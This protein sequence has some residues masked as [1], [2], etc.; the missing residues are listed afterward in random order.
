M[1]SRD[2]FTKIL[3]FGLAKLTEQV[4]E[5]QEATLGATTAEEGTRLGSVVGTVGYMSPEQVQGKPVDHRSDIFSFGC[6]LYE[7]VTRRKPFAAESSIETMHQIIHEN[8]TPVEKVNDRVPA[9]V[10]RLIR[11]CLAKNPEQ[12]LQSAKDL[13][14][15]LREIVDE[16]ESLS[17]SGSSG[18]VVAAPAD[19][20]GRRLPWAWIAG[21]ALVA[22]LGISLAV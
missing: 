16:F 10:R 6:V 20:G 9:E 19:A 7:A 11:R 8:P 3:D 2:G 13:A 17:A 4:G 12:R 1:V 18:T 5:D 14:L 21:A 15:E 22:A